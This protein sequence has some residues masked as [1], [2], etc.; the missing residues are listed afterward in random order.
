M[1]G[2]GRWFGCGALSVRRLRSVPS[3]FAARERGQATV[4]A[5]VLIPVLF[6]ALLLLLQPGILLYDRL[7]HR[8]RRIGNASLPCVPVPIG[9]SL[10]IQGNPAAA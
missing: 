10:H 1:A 2:Q 8:V 6:T 9:T 5:A 3:G 7:K 4:E